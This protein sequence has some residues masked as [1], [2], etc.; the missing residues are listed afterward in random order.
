MIRIT[1]ARSNG[2]NVGFDCTGHAGFAEEGK[3]IVCSAVSAVTQTTVLGITE[4]AKIPAGVSVDEDGI[5]CILG[6][7]ATEK[8][9]EQADLLLSSME[10]GLA[11]I[12][13]AH[14][15]TL[16]ITDREV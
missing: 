8:Q 3:D 15:H 11:A 10:T 1:M 6:K 13:R 4:I 12:G 9:C 2:R 5:R 14:P 16:K 7:D